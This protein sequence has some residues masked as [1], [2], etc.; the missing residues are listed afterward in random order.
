[1]PAEPG[2]S[3]RTQA[4]ALGLSVAGL[5]VSAYLTVEHYTASTALACPQTSS[6]NCVKVTT[7]QQSVFLGIPVALLG[8]I[9]FVAMVGLT[10]PAAWRLT[11]MDRVRLGAAIVGV[12]SVLYLVYAELFLVGSICLWCTAIHVITVALFGLVVFTMTD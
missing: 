3:A 5:A 4:F 6:F 1:M 2:R 8:L 12:I 9:Y 7:S 10:V 11:T